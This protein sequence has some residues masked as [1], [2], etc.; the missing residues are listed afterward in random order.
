MIS[1]FRFSAGDIDT[2]IPFILHYFDPTLF[3][4]ELLLGTQASHPVYIWKALAFF[5]RWI[6]ISSL[7]RAAFIAQTLLIC[8]GAVLFFRQHFTPSRGWI[9][10]LLLL[11]LPV[12]TPGYGMYGLNSYG[13]FH[14]GALAFGIALLA[15]SLLDRGWWVIGGALSGAL[16]LIHPITAVYGA[17]FFFVRALMDFSGSR[18][19]VSILSGSVVLVIIALPSLIPAIQASLAPSPGAVDPAFWRALARLRMNHGYFISAW[20]PERFIQLAGCFALVLIVYRKHAAF[21]R[22]LPLVVVVAGGLLITALADLLTIRFFLRLQLGRC[23]YFLYFIVTALAVDTLTKSEFLERNRQVLT[24][25]TIAAL[26]LLIIYGNAALSGQHGWITAV[27]ITILV[28][29]AV[30]VAL[31]W[32]RP[33]HPVV[34]FALFTAMVLT[35]AT[36][37]STDN[38]RWTYAQEM[39]DPWVSFSIGCENYIPKDSIVMIPLMRQDFRPYAL[40][41]TYCTWKDNA[42]HLFCDKT[43]PEYWRRMQMFGITL[44]TKKRDI[45]A[46]YCDHAIEVARKERIRYVVF[47]KPQAAATGPLVWENSEFGLIDINAWK[48]SDSLIIR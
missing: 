30:A 35:A 46:L 31:G 43:L 41:A 8:A 36:A 23:A 22:L 21:K 48:P 16:F 25:C 12:S 1:G 38:F 13:Y 5:L 26:A 7:I 42:P 17:G 20:V 40:R 2:Y 33:M 32:Y 27:I 34:L 47:E 29:S 37:R 14:A 18:R 28:S 39:R 19:R 11:V 9:L 45:P 10:L 15:Y 44:K 24:A 6:S 4:N 3:K